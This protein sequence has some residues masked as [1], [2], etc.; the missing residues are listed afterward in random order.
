M[1][2]EA[3]PF[4]IEFLP[5]QRGLQGENSEVERLPG[6]GESKC[7]FPGRHPPAEYSSSAC[8]ASFPTFHSLE[9]LPWPPNRPTSL[10]SGMTSTHLLMFLM[11]CTLPGHA[12]HRP[13][14]RPP[15][16]R[17]FLPPPTQAGTPMLC[18]ASCWLLDFSLAHMLR[19]GNPKVLHNRE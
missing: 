19:V 2:T 13:A 4:T 7:S 11:S 15:V 8:S 10:C 16:S 1:Y 9:F 5:G 17:W 3:G 12:Q 14:A 18:E 6:Q